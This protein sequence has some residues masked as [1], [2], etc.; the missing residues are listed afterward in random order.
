M[1]HLALHGLGESYRTEAL[2]IIAACC[3]ELSAF[4]VH[5]TE[6]ALAIEEATVEPVRVVISGVRTSA[7][8][9]ALRRAA[10]N[11]PTPW[12]IVDSGDDA[13]HPRAKISFKGKTIKA[14]NPG[15]LQDGILRITDGG[16][17][18]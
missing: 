12:M 3:G 11:S 6:G 14:R 16:E 1:V 5:G 9:A 4:G 2:Q 15:A 13:G 8:V 17:G 7:G 18:S 10:L